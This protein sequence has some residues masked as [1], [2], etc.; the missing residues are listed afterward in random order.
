[1][2]P[3][4]IRTYTV[5][6]TMILSNTD[7]SLEIKRTITLTQLNGIYIMSQ[8]EVCGQTHFLQ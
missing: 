8:L 7:N 4:S 3:N 1:M 6:S 5:A 2:A